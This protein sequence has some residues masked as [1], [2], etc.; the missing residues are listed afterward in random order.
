MDHVVTGRDG[1][2]A[3]K[4]RPGPG[5]FRPPELDWKSQAWNAPSPNAKPNTT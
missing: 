4:G 5:G 3:F 1:R 2:I